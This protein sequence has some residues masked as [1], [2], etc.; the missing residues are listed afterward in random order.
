VRLDDRLAEAVVEVRRGQHVA[1]SLDPIQAGERAALSAWPERAEADGGVV[2]GT[3][4][5]VIGVLDVRARFGHVDQREE[6]AHVLPRRGDVVQIPHRKRRHHGRELGVE[7][8]QDRHARKS[9]LF[10]GKQ[11]STFLGVPE[12]LDVG[13]ARRSHGKE[14]GEA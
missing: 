10:V 13:M 5:E 14:R 6:L 12:V 9:L 1:A 7:T 8:G 2:V 11:M 4:R 3:R